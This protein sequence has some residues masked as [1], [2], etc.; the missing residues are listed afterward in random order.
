[1]YE[2]YF[3]RKNDATVI[4]YL[5]RDYFPG[6]AKNIIKEKSG[7]SSNK[8]KSKNKLGDRVGLTKT[9]FDRFGYGHGGF[10][11]KLHGLSLKR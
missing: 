9:A 3:D 6:E 10:D 2:L 7:G 1:M 11:E 4:P 8:S 5:E